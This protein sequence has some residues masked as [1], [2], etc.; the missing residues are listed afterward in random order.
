MQ[1]GSLLLQLW[2]NRVKLVTVVCAHGHTHSRKAW[3]E[4]IANAWL[5]CMYKH[6]GN[7]SKCHNFN[8]N[9]WIKNRTSSLLLLFF[10]LY[11]QLA[12]IKIMA[13]SAP[14]SSNNY[15]FFSR[16]RPTK[17]KKNN[18][19]SGYH[20]IVQLDS[21]IPK[22]YSHLSSAAHWKASFS[23]CSTASRHPL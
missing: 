19:Y 1:A 7:T 9:M 5:T 13:S 4:N 18:K 15:K 10:F 17:K 3:A 21:Y 16:N 14:Q 12:H 11:A 23:V 8:S 2:P 22:H 20:L 6:M